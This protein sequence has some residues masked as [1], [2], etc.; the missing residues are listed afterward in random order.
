MKHFTFILGIILGAL[1]VAVPSSATLYDYFSEQGEILPV[2]PI[3][4]ASIRFFYIWE[5][6]SLFM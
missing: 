1:I 4:T 6:I 3:L 5:S 2:N